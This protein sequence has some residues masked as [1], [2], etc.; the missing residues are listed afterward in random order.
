MMMAMAIQKK[1]HFCPLIQ[2]LV[3]GV[4][5]GL[6][7]CEIF[8]PDILSQSTP[9]DSIYCKICIFFGIYKLIYLIN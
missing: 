6:D 5:D 4:W 7:A 1:K 8:W 9:G 2:N 3:V